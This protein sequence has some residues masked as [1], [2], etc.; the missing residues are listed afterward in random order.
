MLANLSK[1]EL[2]DGFAGSAIVYIIHDPENNQYHF[3]DG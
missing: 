2:Q 1:V 3:S